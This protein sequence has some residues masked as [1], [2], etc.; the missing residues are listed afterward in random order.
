MRIGRKRTIHDHA[1]Q[2]P[3]PGGRVL[4]RRPLRQLPKRSLRG[5]KRPDSVDGCDPAQA[6]RFK[7]RYPEPAHGVGRVR[8]RTAPHVPVPVGVWKLADP[9]AVQHDD[10]DTTEVK[11]G[12][13][14][15]SQRRKPWPG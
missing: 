1:H 3:V 10:H 15:V 6:E 7:V 9:S 14:F 5:R 8:Q 11:H 4:S 13:E 12:V 2:F